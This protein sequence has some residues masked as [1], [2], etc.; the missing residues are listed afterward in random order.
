[1][2]DNDLAQDDEQEWAPVGLPALAGVLLF[3]AAALYF[4]NTG[5]RWFPFLDSANLAFHEFGHPFFGLFSEPLAVY[6]GTLGQLIF[7]LA[8]MWHFRRRRAS[9]SFAACAIWLGQNLFNI[10][11]YMGDAQSRVLPLVGG[12]D[13]EYSH[14]WAIILNRWRIIHLDGVLSG[15]LI[16]LAWL[17]IASVCAWL[18]W[19]WWLGRDGD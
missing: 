19:R 8:T 5:Q 16:T 12:A 17:A 14:D 10:A 6:G 7:P 1:M 11:R 15:A 9:A 2:R 18:L 13:P 4:G 3:A